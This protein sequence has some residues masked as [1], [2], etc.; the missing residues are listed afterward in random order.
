VPPG[1]TETSTPGSD[2]NCAFVGA[3]Q[4]L[5]DVSARVDKAIKVLQPEA[6]ATASAFGENCVYADGHSV[7]SAMETDFT[8]K[9]KVADL[10][11][12][13]DL[14][15]WIIKVMK[16]LEA[17]QPGDV[18]GPQS[19]RV[20][21]D[22]TSPPAQVRIATVPIDQYRNLPASTSPVEIFRTFSA[23]P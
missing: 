1:G 4:S 13:S 19:G 2:N 7:F 17:F 22:F 18:P 20:Q 3:D 9:I 12:E 15:G 16:V 5:P 21:I 6:S 8:L 10:K 11:N 23:K 14:G